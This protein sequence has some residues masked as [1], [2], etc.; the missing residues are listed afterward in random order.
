M[1]K[2]LSFK[3]PESE[4]EFKIHNNGPK[5]YSALWNIST[6]IRNKLKYEN[7][8]KNQIKLLEELRDLIPDLEME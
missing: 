8:S 3:C 4:E 2:I 6:F 5:F 1:I 7:L